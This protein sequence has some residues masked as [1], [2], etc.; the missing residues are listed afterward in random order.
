MG[1]IRI[2]YFRLSFKLAAVLSGSLVINTFFKQT[3]FKGNKSQVPV[4]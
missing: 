4:T 2:R 1:E 3:A